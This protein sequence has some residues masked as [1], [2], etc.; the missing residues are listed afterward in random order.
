MQNIHYKL[1]IT[2][3]QT[4]YAQVQMQIAEPHTLVAANGYIE[5]KMAVWTPGS[6]LVREYARMVEQVRVE[7][8]TVRKIN[9]NTWRVLL[10]KST[11]KLTVHYAVYCFEL[12]VRTNYIDQDYALL[13]GAPTFM[14]VAEHLDLPATLDIDMPNNWRTILTA[15][16]TQ[17]TQTFDYH[18]LVDS[19]I[20]LG[21]YD[22]FDFEANGIAHKVGIQGL[23]D[24]NQMQIAA[25]MQRIVESA[26]AIF[27][28]NPCEAYT[29]MTIF[30]QKSRGG[31]EH[32]FSTALIAIREEYFKPEGYEDYLTLIAHEYF[33]V[34]NV[35]RLCPKPL[36][37][38]DYEA[39]NY[40]TLLWQVEG[41]TSY[42][43]NIVMLKAGHISP[44]QFIEKNIEHLNI[45]ENQYGNQ[46]LSLAE[47]SLD[48][49]IKAYRPHE[50]SANSSISYYTKGA[51]IAMLLDFEIIKHTGG[52]RNLDDLM[53]HL[54]QKFYKT[55]KRGFTEEEILEAVIHIAT[56]TEIEKP[57]NEAYFQD[58]FDKY[59]YGT[60]PIFY[61]TYFQLVGLTIIDEN[62]AKRT[63]FL[64]IELDKNA[65]KFV[66]RGSN[67]NLA[68]LQTGDKLVSMNRVESSQYADW[69][70]RQKV[71]KS[72][73][74]KV[75]RDGILRE[76][77]V[78][79]ERDTTRQFK[80]KEMLKKNALQTK[81]YQKWMRFV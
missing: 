67:A 27:G 45:V 23:E 79:I 71:G 76:I 10:D 14:Y 75:L 66:K 47:A 32:L 18:T 65:V 13:N 4:H 55:E 29:F 21:N 37:K 44:E 52:A 12:T 42:Y 1:S 26:T 9:K 5:L 70:K 78:V 48:A 54:Y 11:E 36:D 53:R 17:P 69:I 16:P 72:V 40:T 63:P 60:T 81:Y 24:Y 28:E 35:K 59:I 39:E 19:P 61:H 41:F 62:K 73:K 30:T 20:A 25:D 38:F 43:E 6:Y 74:I 3:P 68:G 80:A 31:L 64:G 50:N 58:F 46:V 7:G 49:W 77:R 34:W 56:L 57:Q 33:H 8:G 22:V 2:Q 51:I 15:L